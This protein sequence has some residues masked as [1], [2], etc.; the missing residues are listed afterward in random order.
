MKNLWPLGLL[1]LAACQSTSRPARPV[2]TIAPPAQTATASGERVWLR[3]DGQ[4]ASSSP[5]LLS[6]F[7][8]DKAD[9]I[10]EAET[11][12]PAAEQCMRRH[13]YIFVPQSQAPQIAAD[14]AAKRAAR[15]H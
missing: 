9:C 15:Q 12:S 14:L 3:T 13:G 6:A 4:R 5:R 2:A 11:V 7:N 8:Q 1:L 10:G